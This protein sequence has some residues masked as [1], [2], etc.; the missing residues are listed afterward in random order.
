MEKFEEKRLKR[1]AA[2]T[3]YRNT[4]KGKKMLLKK[5]ARQRKNPKHLERFRAY[6][7]V[8]EAI[9]SGRLKPASKRKCKD[10]G[11]RA[12]GYH[13]NSYK[14]EDR[15]KVVPLCSPCHRVRHKSV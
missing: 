7:A 10:C 4:E 12:S 3:R 1:R 13:H 5:W 11:K 6:S 8:K 15:L 2:E 14:R 9:R